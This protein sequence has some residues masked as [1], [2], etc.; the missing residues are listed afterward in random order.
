MTISTHAKEFH[1]LSLNSC[2]V[3]LSLGLLTGC[4][5]PTSGRLDQVLDVTTVATITTIGFRHWKGFDTQDSSGGVLLNL[6][7][8]SFCGGRLAGKIVRLLLEREERG[9][10]FFNPSSDT[11]R[12]G[13]FGPSSSNR[14]RDEDDMNGQFSRFP[15]LPF[16]Q[17][18]TLTCEQAGIHQIAIQKERVIL[19][20]PATRMRVQIDSNGHSIQVPESSFV[21]SERDCL[22]GVSK[23]GCYKGSTFNLEYI[24]GGY[25][26]ITRRHA[27]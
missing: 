7:G 10:G 20:T 25:Y 18:I 19:S 22:V 8:V 13:N 24:D 26:K 6:L 5:L 11:N 17:S 23:L 14:S 16:D 9:R 12:G 15:E 27:S 1:D 4:L 21:S 3:A 2:S